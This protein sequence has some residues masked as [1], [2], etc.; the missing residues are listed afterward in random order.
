MNGYF[1]NF[2][3]LHSFCFL[4]AIHC[5]WQHS[6]CFPLD[7]KN[8]GSRGKTFWLESSFFFFALSLQDVSVTAV[9]SGGGQRTE[10]DDDPV[11]K[12]LEM[13]KNDGSKKG[14]KS[15]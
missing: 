5:N 14:V 11:G 3:I 4:N 6:H 10:D 15:G 2:G 8:N 9:S 13:K 12:K 7:E 1:Q